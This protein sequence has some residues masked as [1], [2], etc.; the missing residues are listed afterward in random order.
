MKA[1]IGHPPDIY[2][3][4]YDKYIVLKYKNIYIFVFL[5]KGL[6]LINIDYLLNCAHVSFSVINFQTLF[7]KNNEERNSDQID[8]P[9]VPEDDLDL[10]APSGKSKG[11]KKGSRLS[12]ER[13]YQKK[14]Q[15]E[16]IL[17]R[18]DTYIGSVELVTQVNL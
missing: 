8:I 15:L 17:L 7:D 5:P 2:K 3:I 11:G 14:T 18:P 12:V 4:L 9:D 6:I 13:I 16:H 10:P 1:Y